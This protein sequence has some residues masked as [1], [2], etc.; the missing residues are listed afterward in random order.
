MR[1]FPP[2]VAPLVLPVPAWFTIHPHVSSNGLALRWADT[3]AT[4]EGPLDL[5]YGLRIRTGTADE[6]AELTGRLRVSAWQVHEL[7][8]LHRLDLLNHA[9]ADRHSARPAA[10]R[11]LTP[12][13]RQV[14][15]DLQQAHQAKQDGPGRGPHG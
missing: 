8:R 7:I 5:E 12:E 11:P 13:G 1:D 10:G 4:T 14:L 9:R 15:V 6:M 2:D 3:L